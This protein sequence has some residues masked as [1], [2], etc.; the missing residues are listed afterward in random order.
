M[1]PM[2][3]SE[4][5]LMQDMTENQRLMLQSEM[6]RARKDPTTGILLALCLGGM[7]A[8]RFYLKQTGLGILYLCFFWTFILAIV[9][10]IELFLMKSRVQEYNYAMSIELAQKMNLLLPA[11]PNTPI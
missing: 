6:G 11:S 10:F 9:A 7:G 3:T 4:L 2:D 8:H 1:I 5:V